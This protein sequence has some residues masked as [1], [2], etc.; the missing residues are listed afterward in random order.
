MHL[1][2][3]SR[4]MIKNVKV[5]NWTACTMLFLDF[6]SVSLWMIILN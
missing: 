2:C 5:V 1:T 4:N 3:A 6:V